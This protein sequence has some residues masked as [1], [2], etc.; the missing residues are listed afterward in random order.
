MTTIR[1]VAR[2]LS[3]PFLFL[4]SFRNIVSLPLLEIGRQELLSVGII[5]CFY[6][7]LPPAKGVTGKRSQRQMGGPL[8]GRRD[9][10]PVLSDGRVSGWI[11]RR[12]NLRAVTCERGFLAFSRRAA[13]GKKDHPRGSRKACLFLERNSYAAG[14]IAEKR[15]HNRRIVAEGEILGKNMSPRGSHLLSA[16]LTFPGVS[17][18]LG[19][20]SALARRLQ[21][22]TLHF[23]TPFSVS[24]A[25][26]TPRPC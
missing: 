19:G 22:P 1:S 6:R 17:S 11:S 18:G 8:R 2:M 5:K 16:L 3:I 9:V 12:K 23:P 24:S 15:N 14:I 4:T 20:F 10:G 25:R 26:W 13:R 21:Q 7:N